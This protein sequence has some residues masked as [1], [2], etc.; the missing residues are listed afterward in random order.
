[1]ALG[2]PYTTGTISLTADSDTVAGLGTLWAS[3]AEPGD[4]IHAQ[5]LIGVV[6]TVTSDT[7]LKLYLP[8]AGATASGIDY[9]LLKRS[10]NRYDPAITQDRLRAFLAALADAGGVIYAVT[11]AA[12]DPGLGTDGQWAIKSNATPWRAWRRESGVWVEQ[13]PPSL[14]VEYAGAW[15]A[16]A[17]YDDGALVTYDGSLWLSRAAANA[18][19]QPDTSPSWWALVA[20]RGDVGPQGPQGPQGPAGTNGWVPTAADRYQYST[21]AGLAVE[22]IITPA[23]RELVGSV[24]VGDLVSGTFVKA[25]PYSVAFLRTAN[26]AISLKAGT[27]IGLAGLLYRFAVD[28][29]VQMPTLTA[30]T[31]YAVYLCND[32]TLRADASFTA[33]TG[34]TAA[35]SRRIGGFHFAPGGNAPAQAGGDATAQINPYSLW[36][37]RFRPACNDPRGMTLVAG[38]F[39]VDIYLLGVNHHVDGTSRYNVTIADGSSPP[40]IP[41]A[42]GGNGTATY[43]TVTWWIAVEVLAAYGKQLLSYDEFA[44]AS[45]GTTENSSA[46]TDPVSTILRQAYTSRWGVMLSSGN[47]WIWSRELSYRTGTGAE[48]WKNQTGGR[49]QIYIQNDTGLAAALI[50]G[51]SLSGSSSGSRAAFWCISPWDTADNIG[52][53]GRCDHL[54]QV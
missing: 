19:H 46:G 52:A 26:G 4:E 43:S 6:E 11:G 14:A 51:Y 35:T 40:K 29:A 1:M 47:M 30:G 15:S 49:G 33:P 45:Y 38:G 2:E 17:A 31:D 22:G 48:G 16:P 7:A 20:R 18:G 10:P 42:F 39:W 23:A 13:S 3:V 5:G 53:R 12:P 44:A 50:G 32:G 41:S 37:L 28:T 24:A 9:V 21:G 36:D 8:W 34:F 27:T 25:D 54:C